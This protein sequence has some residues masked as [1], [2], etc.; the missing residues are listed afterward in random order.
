MTALGA[1]CA[2]GTAGTDKSE[3]AEEYTEMADTKLI[4]VEE[5]F[6]ISGLS[7]DDYKDIDLEK[8]IDDYEITE[9]NAK[10][11]NIRLLLDEYGAVSN[12]KDVNYIFDSQNPVREADFTA[13]AAAIAFYENINTGLH[14]VYYDLENAL[15]YETTEGFLFDD[16]NLAEAA[17]YADGRELLE[18]LESEGVFTWSSASDTDGID[19]YQSM[20][21]AVLYKDGS[22][23][24]VTASGILSELLPAEYDK[25]KKMLFEG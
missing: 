15:R 20:E 16:L 25:I 19:D 24:R 17:D 13:D 1:G 5:L 11:L 9:D 22:A 10:S 3:T 18:K 6:N 21:L 4:S 7:A 2:S 14:C 8:F 12:I 23:F